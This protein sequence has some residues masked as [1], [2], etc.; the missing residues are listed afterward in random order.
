MRR[1]QHDVLV[2]RLREPRRFIEVIA[3][4]RQVGKTTLA[5]GAAVEC[6]LPHRYASAD[7]PAPPHVR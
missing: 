4:P 2:Q 1:A 5:L 7:G 6:G 3:G